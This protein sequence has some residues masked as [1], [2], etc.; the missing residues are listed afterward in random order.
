MSLTPN[1]KPNTPNPNNPNNPNQ[2]QRPP[3]S[4]NKYIIYWVIGG[5]IL[6]FLIYFLFFYNRYKFYDP[7]AL[8]E[9]LNSLQ[10]KI[11]L[12]K[13]QG[14]FSFLNNYYLGNFTIYLKDGT[15]LYYQTGFTSDMNVLDGW[16]NI[17]EK[18]LPGAIF[19]QQ[20][21]A[22]L[23][24][25]ILQFLI[26][27]L[28]LGAIFFFIM[29]YS[30]KGKGLDFNLKKNK[31][32]FGVSTTKFH[33]V[34]GYSEEKIELEEIVHFLSHPTKYIAMGAR[35]PKGVLMVG[36]PGTGKTLFA[37]AVAGE[38]GVPIM[39]ISGSNFVEL[40]VG[41]GAARVREMFAVAQKSSPCII[42]IDEIDAVGRQRG[43]GMGGGNDEREQT[44][45]QL[46]VEMDG[47]QKNKGIIVLAATN[48]PDV[49]DPGL[50][51]PGRFDRTVIFHVPTVSE[52]EAILKV[53]S[54]NK[55]IAFD[56]DFLN[57]A[58]RTQGFTGAQLENVI[59]ES[60]LLATRKNKTI[61]ELEDIDE[62]IDRTIGG[63]AKTTKKYV[64][65]EKM[66]ISYHEC[67]HVV[68]G[69]ILE[70]AHE[71][72]KV[73]I[74]PRGFAGGYTLMT[75]KQELMLETKK[76]LYDRIIGL[77]GGRASEEIVFG[78]DEITTGAKDDISKST[79]IAHK[80]VAELGMSDLGLIEYE[81]ASNDPFL[82]RD[83]TTWKSHSSVTA[84]KIDDEVKKIIDQCYAKCKDILN[85]NRK[86][87]DLLATSLK[88]REIL[89]REQILYIYKHLK[90]LPKQISHEKNAPKLKSKKIIIKQENP[91]SEPMVVGQKADDHFD[92]INENDQE[93][94]KVIYP[95]KDDDTKVSKDDKS[96]G[97]KGLDDIQDDE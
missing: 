87:L 18:A 41:L 94:G 83:Y 73:T 48:R 36:A 69:L 17:L 75:P 92:N 9:Q 66:L 6:V 47:F 7:R 21:G 34:A 5:I 54:R 20:G 37:K 38:A 25:S 13:S 67:G 30:M 50:L 72:Q 42:F 64:D 57:I 31:S 14:V 79:M 60:A 76:D 28:V 19:I 71:V 24:S 82:G 44:L 1:Q 53:H 3:L 70:G 97:P 11:D 95:T 43:A 22:S 23:F 56:V 12:S 52:R 27:A 15:V 51:R 49:L 40:F 10:G 68:I 90:P 81:K 77:L 33:D 80:M 32:V 62:A 29:R 2:P 35:V 93:S 91:T 8:A 4:R 78:P 86:L 58:K 84:T 74:I 26:P 55:N 46:L 45:N 88:E 61:I 59:N 63:L 16:F 65:R 85:K 89:T 39:V 96:T